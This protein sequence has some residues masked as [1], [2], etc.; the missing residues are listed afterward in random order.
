[1]PERQRNRGKVLGNDPDRKHGVP[2]VE[3]KLNKSVCSS[4]DVFRRSAIIQ[5]DE[6][7]CAV[8]KPLRET[9]PHFNLVL[10]ANINVKPGVFFAKTEERLVVQK[11]GADQNNVSEFETERPR[12]LLNNEARFPRF[13]G[14]NNK[15]VE[16]DI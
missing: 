16:W 3:T 14:P 13:G 7:V 15:G 8:K 4:L 5:N 11:G 2:S 10:L 6:G 12:Y 9:R 1:M